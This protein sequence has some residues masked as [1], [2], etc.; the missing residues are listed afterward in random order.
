MLCTTSLRCHTLLAGV[1]VLFVYLGRF[2]LGTEPP[3]V[4]CDQLVGWNPPPPPVDCLCSW[5]SD[6][7]VMTM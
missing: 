3:A 1:V 6:R 5:C 4:M 2:A 7:V